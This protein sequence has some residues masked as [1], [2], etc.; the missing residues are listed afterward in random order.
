MASNTEIISILSSGVSFQRMLLPFIIASTLIGALSFALGNFII[1]PANEV[2]LDFENTYLKNPYRNRDKNI[3]MQINPGSFVYIESYNSNKNIGYKFSMEQFNQGE[4]QQKLFSN[5]VEWDS[6]SGKWNIHHYFIR[7]IDGMSESLSE[8]KKMDTLINLH[9]ADFNVRLNNVET[10]NFFELNEYIQEERMKGSKKSGVSSYRKAQTNCLSFC[11]NYFNAN[12]GWGRFQKGKRW[13][14]LTSRDWI[15]DKFF[16][17]N[18]H[19]SINN[20]CY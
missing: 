5:Y 1:P 9:P 14:R 17:Y 6:T 4:L 16:L 3:H 2:R 12:C 13:C 10:M 11:D 18:V 8:G 19:A 15:T 7:T 20:L